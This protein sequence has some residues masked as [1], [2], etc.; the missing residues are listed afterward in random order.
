[1]NIIILGLPGS[2]KT[3]FAD[4]LASKI[5]GLRIS[6]DTVRNHMQQINKY[7]EVAK[8]E[9]YYEMLKLMEKAIS[10]NQN[11]VLDGTFYKENIRNIFKEKAIMLNS[12]LSFIEI[13]ANSSVIKGRLKKE[14]K[15][16]EANF[17]VYLKIKGL[18]EP[19]SEKHLILYS[20]KGT[21]DEMQD[22]ALAY[23]NYT[24]GTVADS[25]I[26]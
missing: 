24:D 16:S 2:G 3:Y 14:R 9:V 22:K 5:S 15:E 19:L 10:N 7:D 26:N 18:F 8:M 4:K 17:K 6:S 12:S 13:R 11:V 1:M 25:N 21:L 20:D 23:I